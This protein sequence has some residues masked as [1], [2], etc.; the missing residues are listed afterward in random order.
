MKVEEPADRKIFQRQRKMAELRTGSK[1][2]T[3]NITD[4]ISDFVLATRS[5]DSRQAA[6]CLW[7]RPV[8]PSAAG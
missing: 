5:L 8:R 1:Y 3:K 4:F 7:K 6:L 2:V